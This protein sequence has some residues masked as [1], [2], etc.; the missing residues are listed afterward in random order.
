MIPPP[1]PLPR[2][3]WLTVLASI[4]LVAPVLAYSAMLIFG[5]YTALDGRGILLAACSIVGVLILGS[6]FPRKRGG[7]DGKGEAETRP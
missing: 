4:L 3:R 1:R 7:A 2:P 6:E 5:N